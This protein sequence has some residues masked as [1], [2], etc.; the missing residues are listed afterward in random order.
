MTRI[1]VIKLGFVNCFLLESEK[2]NIL[3]DTGSSKN[4]N[5]IWDY[6]KKN[7]IDP[8]TIKLIIL[9]HSH[10]DHVGGLKKVKERTG[11]QVLIHE[12]EGQLFEKGKSPR[13]HPIVWWVKLFYSSKKDVSILPVEPDI[14]I[15]DDFQLEPFGIIGRVVPTPGH[16]A[17]SVSV[18]VDS[19]FAFIGDI[20]MKFPFISGRS[21]KPI[22]AEDMDAVYS[23]WRKILDEG[24]ETIFPSHGKAFSAEVLKKA[25]AKN[26]KK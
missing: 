21:Y 18:F 22:I 26:E 1:H 11:A 17:G 5:P 16:T 9:T 7:G 4:T 2:G 24:V 3:I 8:K 19:K 23:S 10:Q 13:F 15:M 14:Q 20:A 12:N 25:L 6:L